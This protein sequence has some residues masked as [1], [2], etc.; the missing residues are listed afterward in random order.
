[1]PLILSFFIVCGFH[2]EHLFFYNRPL[3]IAVLLLAYLSF[4]IFIFFVNLWLITPPSFIRFGLRQIGNFLSC[5]PA[6]W[7]R[8]PFYT[9]FLTKLPFL[10]V[11]YPGIIP[12]DT[13]G[14][15][16]QFLGLGDLSVRLS[17]TDPF[18]TASNHLPYLYTIVYGGIMKAGILIAN[19]NVAFFI[20]TLLQ[21]ALLSWILASFIQFITQQDIHKYAQRFLILFFS[22]NPIIAIWSASLVKDTFL[23]IMILWYVLDLFRIVSSK[24]EILRKRS[25]QCTHIA[26]LF[27]F[28]LSKNQCFLIEVITGIVL[29]Y[30]FR[31]EI[32]QI[33]YT[34]GFASVLYVG[35]WLNLFLPFCHVAPV[36]KQE[37]LGTLFQ[38]TA[39]Y[40]IRHADE[41]TSQEIAHI[42]KVLPY[43][44]L[45]E[46]YDPDLH[47]P[48]KFNYRVT[49]TNEEYRNYFKSWFNMLVKHPFTYIESVLRGCYGFFYP[50]QRFPIADI[51]NGIKP[52]EYPGLYEITPFMPRE[53]SGLSFLLRIP[54]IGWF[55]TPGFLVLLFLLCTYQIVKH[56]KK[57]WIPVFIPA[58]LSV[59]ILFISPQNGCFRYIMPIGFLL[60]FYITLLFERKNKIIYN[61]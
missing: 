54:V 37:V 53:K 60:P 26:V 25:F 19:Q 29:L 18:Y 12:A 40:S 59:L 10:I 28:A 20:A 14:S 41:V 6:F 16:E 17:T 39:L 58:I 5:L 35:L 32:R 27:F 55:F 42:D 48:V 11:L 38:Q 1:M 51:A 21:T 3:P 4:A 50:S 49:I 9:L 46:L 36:G 13:T 44:Q 22:F 56:G 7:F 45:T 34:Y 31:K 33:A 30:F 57:E 2:F 24:G 23:S 43:A 15:I 52:N 61:K 8:H 47:D